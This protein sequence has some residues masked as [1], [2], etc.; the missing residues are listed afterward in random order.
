MAT[1]AV[2]AL[3]PVADVERA[4]VFYDRLDLPFVGAGGRPRPRYAVRRLAGPLWARA[5]VG[6]RGWGGGPSLRPP[7]SRVLR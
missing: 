5:G 3:L 4:K 7:R 2:T 6:F 1:S